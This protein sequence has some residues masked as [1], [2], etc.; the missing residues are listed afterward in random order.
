M[1]CNGVSITYPPPRLSRRKIS[2]LSLQKDCLPIITR[3]ESKSLRAARIS[4]KLKMH[5]G[6]AFF[7]YSSIVMISQFASM[8]KNSSSDKLV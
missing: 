5:Y 8:S 1:L 6:F 2:G 7:A 4:I 3:R